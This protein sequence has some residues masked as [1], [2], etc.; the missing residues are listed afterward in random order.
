MLGIDHAGL[1]SIYD[2]GDHTAF[3]LKL[4]SGSTYPLKT[5]APL[6]AA[7]GLLGLCAMRLLRN[8]RGG[9]RASACAGA[10]DRARSR[11]SARSPQLPATLTS[12]L[13]ACSCRHTTT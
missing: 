9:R 8:E 4:H 6:A 10:R 7:A 11:R 2:A 12:H 1:Q 5:L 13:A 3:N